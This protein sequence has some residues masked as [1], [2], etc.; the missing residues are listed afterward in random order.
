MTAKAANGN[1]QW[2]ILRVTA[3][4]ERFVA[5]SLAE[6]GL[7]AYA[8]MHVTEARFAKRKAVRTR[9]L[10]PSYVFANLPD[11]HSLFL[12]LEIRSV[13]GMMCNGE[14]VPR[15]VPLSAMGGLLLADACHWFDE[16]WQ[17][18]KIKGR[19]YSHRWQPGERVRI[20]TGPYQDFIGTVLRAKGRSRMDLMITVFGRDGEVNIEEKHL[21]KPDAEE[22][23]ASK[24]AA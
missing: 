5:G 17:P 12:A 9:P 23:V 19:R 2:V 22:D 6:H 3:R 18:P 24:R 16:T 21:R 7:L 13:H 1:S 8:P 11:D 15:R 4:Q 14:G 20:A 10:M